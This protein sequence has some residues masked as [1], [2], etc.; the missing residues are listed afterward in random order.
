MNCR[1][2][3]IAP[4]ILLSLLTSLGCAA[5]WLAGGATAGIGTY[6]YITGELQGTEEVSLDRAYQ[7]A[8]KA[9]GDLQFTVTSKQKDAFYGEVIARRAT[10]KKV[11]V[12]LNKQTNTATEI[13]I[14]VGTFGDES[15]SN[16]ILNTMK[17]YY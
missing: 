15:M 9:M 11:T 1:Q 4:I 5:V 7:A 10:G 2:S 6:K 8:Q 16:E 14:R 12:K 3:L 17:K 13:K